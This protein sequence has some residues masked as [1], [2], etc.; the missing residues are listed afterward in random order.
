M[1]S[2]QQKIYEKERVAFEHGKKVF[3]FV[4]F[5]GLGV[6]A[7]FHNCFCFGRFKGQMRWPKGPPPLALNP[8]Y[9]LLLFCFVVGGGLFCR[10]F[11]LCFLFLKR[12]FS[13]WKKEGIFCSFSSV[14]L[15]FFLACLTSPFFV[16]LSLYFYLVLFLL[17][18]FLVFFLF[19]FRAF[20][21][22]SFLACSLPLFHAKNNINILSFRCCFHQSFLFFGSLFCFDFQIS[23]SYLYFFLI[24]RLWAPPHLT[25][26]FFG[27][28]VFLVL[29]WFYFYYF[30]FVFVCFVVGVCWCLGG[31]LF[32]LL[33]FVKLLFV[34]FVLEC[35]SCSCLVVIFVIFSFVFVL[36]FV[37]VGVV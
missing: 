26:P 1:M 23:L 21:C 10:V 11:F 24:L 17:S 37:T 15:C 5:S 3:L 30:C 18:S 32:L 9:I 35:F 6:Y 14:S 16:P 33:C 19:S 29:C 28:F 8:P 4:F 7:C 2:K 31:L 25:L 34:L 36:F 22:F 27:V 13:L 12:L 20:F